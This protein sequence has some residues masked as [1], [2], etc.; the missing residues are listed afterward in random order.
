MIAIFKQVF[1]LFTFALAGFFLSKKKLVNHSHTPLLSVFLVNIF[2]PC[3][4]FRTFAVNFNRSYI[5]ANYH[6]IITSVTVICILAVA[7]HF[8]SRLFDKRDY[9]RRICEY[10]LVV[11]NFGYMGY[12]LAESILGTTGLLNTMMF[13]FP[14][15]F[16]TYTVGFCSLTKRE[17]SFKKLLNPV[18]IAIIS[19]MIIGLSGIHL[20]ELF[21]DV[22]S[23]SASCMAPVSMLLTGIVVSEFDFKSLLKMKKVYV[24]TI[25]RLVVI[26]VTTGFLLSLFCSRIIVQTAVVLYAMPCGLNTIVFPRLVGEDCS[27]GAGLAFV[28][29]ILA[30]LT[31]PLVLRLFN[32]GI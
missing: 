23:K 22:L 9:Q 7:M 4:I 26:P 25:L 17:L 32:I 1:I 18:I 11:P 3:N 20:P 21:T 27:I 6:I 19:G 12:A 10:S 28:S 13:G 24:I 29:N 16:Y 8:F 31:I 15:S 30:C 14:V 2:L 5:K